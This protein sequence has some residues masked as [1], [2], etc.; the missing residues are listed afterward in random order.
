[1]SNIA[2]IDVQYPENL[3]ELHNTYH[4]YQKERKLKT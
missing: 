1:M 4:F 3:H 2:K